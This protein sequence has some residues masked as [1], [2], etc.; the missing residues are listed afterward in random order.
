MMDSRE[1]Q[2]N[3]NLPQSQLLEKISQGRTECVRQSLVSRASLVI[4]GGPWLVLDDGAQVVFDAVNA[5]CGL[6]YN[7]GALF[8]VTQFVS[9]WGQDFHDEDFRSL[10]QA[11]ELFIKRKP[12]WRHHFEGSS[13]P[14]QLIRSYIA[15]QVLDQ[16]QDTTVD[17]GSS[18]QS[19]VAEL[20]RRR[21]PEHCTELLKSI[22]VQGQNVRVHFP[23][24]VAELN[25]RLLARGV[26]A[27]RTN[28]S[29][30][31]LHLPLA[32]TVPDLHLLAGQLLSAMVDYPLTA[33]KVS[34]PDRLQYFRFC[35]HLL[36][37]KQAIARGK[38][39]SLTEDL[40]FLENFLP[41]ELRTT[42]KIVLVD[43]G[44][45]GDYRMA[46]DRLQKT[47]YEPA[48]QTGLPTFDH[49][50]GDPYG[51][52]ILVQVD[53]R[54]AGFASAGP[55]G[56][57]PE[58]RGTLEDPDREDRRVLYPLDLTVAAD[59]RGSLGTYLKRAMVLLAV[60]RKHKAFHGRNRDRL[61]GAM[62]AIN[63]SLGSYQIRHLSNDYPD[64]NRYR[65]CIYYRCPLRWPVNFPIE[66]ACD[67]ATNYNRM[68]A[69]VNA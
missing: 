50:F 23:G 26:L 49:L 65:D 46:V 10:R 24:G 29:Q 12:E 9:A 32:A 4:S 15:T 39:R 43:G 8:G 40:E 16:F 33:L 54:L 1:F 2:L 21:M 38:R 25:R 30:T 48:R 55:I 41:P 52:G 3:Q 66:A 13:S 58:E 64:S 59:F 34:V 7:A 20:A 53:G 31:L 42:G 27:G 14:R 22:H 44:N 68:A 11:S 62:W 35:Q 17:L 45:W 51:F 61:A 5:G 63:L 36:S 28:T 18:F 60:G 37:E 69:L 56:L 6:G 67:D 57:F 47:V 19:I